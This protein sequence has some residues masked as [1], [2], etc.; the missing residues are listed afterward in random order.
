MPEYYLAPVKA[1]PGV[2][3]VATDGEYPLVLASELQY[4]ETVSGRLDL[5]QAENVITSY[6][7]HYTKLYEIR[8][9]C[10]S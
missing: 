1:A 6:S 8:L 5:E 7:I 4:G 9:S 10:A 3:V 2:T